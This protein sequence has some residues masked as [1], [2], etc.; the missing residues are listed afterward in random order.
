MVLKCWTRYTNPPESRRYIN[1][2]NI[3]SQNQDIAK[4]RITKAVDNKELELINQ[5]QKKQME[6]IPEEDIPAPPEDIV[7]PVVKKKRIKLAKKKKT[8][9]DYLKYS[10]EEQKKLGE[11]IEKILDEFSHIDKEAPFKERRLAERERIEEI[12]KILRDEFK[13]Y[14]A[15]VDMMN[16]ISEAMGSEVRWVAKTREKKLGMPYFDPKEAP[17]TIEY[18][19]YETER[20]G[21]RDKVGRTIDWKTLTQDALHIPSIDPQ[22]RPVYKQTGDI[23]QHIVFGIINKLLKDKIK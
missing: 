14:K 19:E 18:M 23:K 12:W 15:L 1:C 20:G 10:N 9:E 8:T 3:T 21:R 6:D 11:K 22:D 16:K 13:T 4:P 5:M 2:I 7:E 17:Q